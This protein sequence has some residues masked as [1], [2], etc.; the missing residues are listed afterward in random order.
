MGN[1][2]VPLYYHRVFDKQPDINLLCVTPLKFEQQIKYLKKHY[3]ILRFED[4]WENTDRDSVVITFDDGY[5]DNYEFAMPILEELQ[6]PAAVFVSTGVLEQDTQLWW[7]ELDTILLAGEQFP[8][9]FKL[10]DDIFGCAWNTTTYGHRLNCYRGLHTLMKNY[11]NVEQRERW[12]MQLR[13]W[14]KP[15]GG[16]NQTLDVSS[17]KKLAQSSYITI[18]AHT[19]SHPSLGSL[20][21]E[22]Q[23]KEIMESI[24]YLE[25]LLGWTIDTF[26]YPFGATQED[27][28]DETIQICKEAGIKKAASTIPGIWYKGSDPYKIPRNI[29]RDW[30]PYEFAT[31]MDQYFMD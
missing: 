11:S 12:S 2:V 31:M 20:T 10:E 27:F 18:G 23:E 16:E 14:R 8:E 29:V 30:G 24:R 19:V 15:A 25:R 3:N 21:Y 6:V 5:M 17:C 22:E 9:C 4:D 26:S 1:R 7:D 13:R 28:T